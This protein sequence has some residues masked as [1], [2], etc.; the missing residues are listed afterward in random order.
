MILKDFSRALLEDL[1][2]GYPTPGDEARPV[3]GLAVE[4]PAKGW[5][6]EGEI[7]ITAREEL[8]EE[9]LREVGGAGAPAVV[10][11]KGGEVPAEA[12][13][14]A[15]ALGLGLFVVE[16]GVPLRRLFS[17]FSGAPR[18]VSL[19]YAGARSG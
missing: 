2:A 14:R 11:R 12:A 13:Q 1:G 6:E 8:D 19:A 9:F 16:P 17:V 15:A 7:A 4:E 5:L 18:L 10:W 3:L